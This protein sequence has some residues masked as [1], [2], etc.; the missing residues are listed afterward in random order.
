MVRKNIMTLVLETGVHLEWKPV[1]VMKTSAEGQEGYGAGGDALQTEWLGAEIFGMSGYQAEC[2]HSHA[3]VCDG[4][5]SCGLWQHVIPV[6]LWL[7]LLH[8]EAGPSELNN[9]P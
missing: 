9:A 6:P 8:Y 3:N 1:R 5:G 4:A 2:M 7:L